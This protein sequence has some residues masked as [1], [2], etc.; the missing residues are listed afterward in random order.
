[1]LGWN[2]QQS[3]PYIIR[4][5]KLRLNI[6]ARYLAL[7]GKLRRSHKILFG[8]PKESSQLGRI[9]AEASIKFKGIMKVVVWP[10]D[11]DLTCAKEG[12]EMG[13]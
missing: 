2:K 4:I 3:S 7:M 9:G 12:P 5:S 6:R 1:M 13:V 11:P 10:C 8:K